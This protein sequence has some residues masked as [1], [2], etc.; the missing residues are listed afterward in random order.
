M[1]AARM[2]DLLTP[3]LAIFLPLV[4]GRE[5]AVRPGDSTA[6]LFSKEGSSPNLHLFSPTVGRALRLGGRRADLLL[7]R[8]Y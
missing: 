8:T 1:L 4:A 3:S 7:L 5:A 6:R 2:I